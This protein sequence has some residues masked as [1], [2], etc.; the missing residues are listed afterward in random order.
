MGRSSVFVNK[1]P[2]LHILGNTNNANDKMWETKAT[3]N[4]DVTDKQPRCEYKMI[5]NH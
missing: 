4:L 5:I 1:I 2:L 3:D